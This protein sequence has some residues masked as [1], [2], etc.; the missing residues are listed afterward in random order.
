MKTLRCLLILA[1]LPAAAQNVVSVTAGGKS[2]TITV[3]PPITVTSVVCPVTMSPGQTVTCTVT[4][5]APAP[6]G[7]FPISPYAATCKQPDSSPCATQPTLNPPN[8]FTVRPG[9]TT[10][11]FTLS[12]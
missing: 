5:S 7:G 12:I 10:A 9:N 4:I 1:A 8:N 2:T 11:D 6:P 3:V